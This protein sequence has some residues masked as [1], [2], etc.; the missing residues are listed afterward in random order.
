MLMLLVCRPHFEQQRSRPVRG[1]KGTQKSIK[2]GWTLSFRSPSPNVP[3]RAESRD[4]SEIMDF[5]STISTHAKYPPTHDRH[6][7]PFTSLSAHH[8][9]TFLL[10]PASTPCNWPVSYITLMLGLLSLPREQRIYKIN[11]FKDVYWKRIEPFPKHW[12]YLLL[13]MFRWYKDTELSNIKS[14]DE[15]ATPFQ[16][17]FNLSETIKEK[18]PGHPATLDNLPFQQRSGLRL[19][20]LGRQQSPARNEKLIGSS[21]YLFLHWLSICWKW[22]WFFTYGSDAKLLLKK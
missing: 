12:G 16:D 19:R 9:C 14:Q 6:L 5:T 7:T 22:Y 10:Q 17:C 21:L 18:Y 2:S 20:A 3:Q 8:P 1:D 13:I 11:Q 4:N 15:K